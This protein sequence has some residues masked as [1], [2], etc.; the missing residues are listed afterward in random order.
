MYLNGQGL[1]CTHTVTAGGRKQATHGWPGAC[2]LMPAG[3]VHARHGFPRAGTSF[4]DRLSLDNQENNRVEHPT[5]PMKFHCAWPLNDVISLIWNAGAWS[6]D[7]W[8]ANQH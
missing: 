7:N 3:V 1:H 6:L 5:C 8:L 2:V 4:Q